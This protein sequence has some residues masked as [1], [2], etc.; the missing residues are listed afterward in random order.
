VQG[1]GSIDVN[2]TCD[3]A[4]R[5]ISREEGTNVTTFKWDH[6]DCMRETQDGVDLI[7]YIPDGMLHKLLELIWNLK[8][9]GISIIGPFILKFRSMIRRKGSR[10][11]SLTGG[12]AQ[13]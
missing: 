4:G 2:F 9:K 3:M 13:E 5:L 8:D 11:P 10:T 6:W 12:A 1:P 7:Y